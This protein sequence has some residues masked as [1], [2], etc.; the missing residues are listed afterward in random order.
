[1]HDRIA[2]NDETQV[3]TT[4][5]VLFCPAPGSYY[6]RDGTGKIRAGYDANVNLQPGDRV[7]FTGLPMRYQPVP[8]FRIQGLPGVPWF[9]VVSME[10][11]GKGEFPD[12]LPIGDKDLY[13]NET[14][15]EKY[16][17]EF[18]TATGR[19]VGYHEYWATYSGPGWSE[20]VKL[21]IIYLDVFGRTVQVMFHTGLNLKE[22]FPMGTMAEFTGT[23]RLSQ[24][25]SPALVERASVHVLVPGLEHARVL[26]WPPFWEIPRHRQNLKLA[27]TSL[28]LCLA[29]GAFGWWLHRRRMNLHL[30]T[31]HRAELER[32]LQKEQELS[33]L[34]TRF[35]SIVSHEFRTPL[36]IIGSS[37]EI[38]EHY[39]GKLTAEQRKEHLHA[40]TE[41]VK[42]TARMME[43][44]LALSRMDSGG[45]TFNPA[46]LD[47][48]SFCER[49]CDEMRSAT[50]KRNPIELE[51]ARDIDRPLPLDESLL[52]HILTNLLSNAVKYSADGSPVKLRV[53]RTSNGVCFEV[54]DHGI[55]I[56]EADRDRL[57]EAFHRADNVGQVHGTGLGLVIAKRCCDLHGGQLAFES[58]N[59]RG[60][61]FTVILPIP[62]IAP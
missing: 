14:V 33:K 4:C 46:P 10:K 51:V 29:G 15:H 3:T 37:A 59:G 38:L 13:A 18:V 17:G 34:K 61:T 60:T 19:V 12:P 44:A 26:R 28:F 23:C 21:D 31:E 45:V 36:G 25:S 53:A 30:A 35:V 22:A 50:S 6:L 32:A 5:T 56:P 20:R 43:D 47:V 57:F 62:S 24:T 54:E 39:E 55:G 49:L 42:R 48:R 2:R 7:R 52:R 1:M 16:D 58:E 41:N 11:L 8:S 9:S 27:G 40:I